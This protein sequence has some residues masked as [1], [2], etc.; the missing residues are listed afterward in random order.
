[1][2]VGSWLSLRFVCG[3]A[4]GRRDDAVLPGA[5]IG[6]FFGMM[7]GSQGPGDH[8]VRVPVPE[9]RGA[10]PPGLGWR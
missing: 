4:C 10:R 3:P 5:A 7:V 9:P 2:G 8:W 6:L 1:M